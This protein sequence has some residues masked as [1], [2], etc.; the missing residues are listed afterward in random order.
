[1]EAE[2]LRKIIAQV[3]CDTCEG[4]AKPCGFQ[5]EGKDCVPETSRAIAERLISLNLIK[6]NY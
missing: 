1:M 2:N 3:F 4:V 6:D 5:K